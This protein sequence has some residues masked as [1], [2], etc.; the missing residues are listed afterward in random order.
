MIHGDWDGPGHAEVPSLLEL[1]TLHYGS[2]TYNSG[3]R[4]C[5]AVARR[6]RALP[7]EYADKA[8]KVDQEYCGTAHGQTG[9]V[10]R[11]LQSF[12]A[13]RGLVFGAWAEASPE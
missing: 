12:G 8:R 4:R 6:A 10:A 2:S 9:P 3:P 1:K 13:V 7:A 11:K 5:E